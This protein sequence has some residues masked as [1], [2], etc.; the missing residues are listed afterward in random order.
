MTDPP[1]AQSATLSS[2]A[3]TQLLARLRWL[4][5]LLDNAIPIP[6]TNY[7][8][9]LDPLLGL[10][11]GGGDILGGI[12]SLYLIWQAALLGASKAS[13]LRMGLNV[14][15]ETL[16]GVVPVLGDLFDV[17]WKANL[18]NLALLERQLLDSPEA[19]HKADLAFIMILLGGLLLILLSAIALTLLVISTAMRLI[20]R[21]WG[22]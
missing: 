21:S 7:R 10:V 2:A 12:L 18:K 20:H 9:G 8:L 5:Q 3:N 22:G 4:S 14:I 6:G 1:H 16:V 15:I 13:L 11:P 19:A 17:A